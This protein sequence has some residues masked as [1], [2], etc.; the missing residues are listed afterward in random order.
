MHIRHLLT[1]VDVPVDPIVWDLCKTVGRY[2]AGRGGGREEKQ[3]CHLS[4]HP[5]AV[6]TCLCVF[7]FQSNK[8]SAPAAALRLR[9]M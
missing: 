7:R 5:A 6:L 3:Q 1:S 8:Q 2:D 9:N 4:L